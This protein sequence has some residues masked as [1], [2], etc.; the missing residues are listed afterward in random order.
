M[1]K[2]YK[3]NE[4]EYIKIKKSHDNLFIKQILMSNFTILIN[5]NIELLRKS[6]D[7]NIDDNN[8]NKITIMGELNEAERN[9]KIVKYIDQSVLISKLYILILN[10]EETILSLYNPNKIDNSVSLKKWF[11]FLTIKD[12]VN[13]KSLYKGMYWLIERYTPDNY[14]KPIRKNMKNIFKGDDKTR[15]KTII[16]LTK[17]HYYNIKDIIIDNYNNSSYFFKTNET[18][19]SDIINKNLN[20]DFK[21]SSLKK[22]GIDDLSIKHFYLISNLIKKL[23]FIYNDD[24][25]N[26]YSYILLNIIVEEFNNEFFNIISNDKNRIEKCTD[27]TEDI[28]NGFNTDIIIKYNKL[29][30]KYVIE[31]D[32]LGNSH[33]NTYDI[34]KKLF[35]DLCKELKI[36]NLYKDNIDYYINTLCDIF[37]KFRIYLLNFIKINFPIIRDFNKNLYYLLIISKR[38][39]DL[40]LK[41]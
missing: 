40:Q 11:D 26:D 33:I 36:Y 19:K 32:L 9:L 10:N 5:N 14:S 15:I 41:L 27:E 24:Y 3:L 30:Y 17:K 31:H 13:M 25:K 18:Y 1:D 34:I 22:K 4:N 35:I 2:I 12:N 37:E 16:Y 6:I 21:W 38:Y 28:V 20:N 39:F 29:L 7:I 23:I 8:P